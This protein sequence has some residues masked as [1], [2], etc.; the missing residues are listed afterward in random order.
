[1]GSTVLRLGGGT[2]LEVLRLDDERMSF[3]LH[4]GSLALRV[5]SREVA[6]E[7]ELVTAEARLHP[8]RSGH[9]RVDRIDDTT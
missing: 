4:G 2:E 6:D 3:Q 7:I 5:R 8:L 1:M 9:Y